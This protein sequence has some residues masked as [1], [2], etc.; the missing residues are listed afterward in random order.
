MRT[1]CKYVLSILAYWIGGKNTTP[2]GEKSASDYVKHKDKE[3]KELYIDRFQK[4]D[5]CIK[6]GVKAAGFCSKDIIWNMATLQASVAD[7]NKRCKHLNV[8][9]KWFVEISLNI[10]IQYV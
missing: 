4:N 10:Y 9:M 8:E 2:F 7:I 5:D 3:R 6:S 1:V